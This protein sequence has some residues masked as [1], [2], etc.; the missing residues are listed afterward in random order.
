MISDKKLFTQLFLIIF[1]IGIIVLLFLPLISLTATAKILLAAAASALTSFMGMKIINRNIGRKTAELE[2]GIEKILETDNFDSELEIRER[3]SFGSLSAKINKI[4]RVKRVSEKALRESENLYKTIFETSE[5]AFAML[6]NNFQAFYI[7]KKFSELFGYKLDELEGKNLNKLLTPAENFKLNPESGIP[8]DF[9]LK[10]K[11]GTLIDVDLLSSPITIK[12]KPF[13]LLRFTDISEIKK[14]E[15]ETKKHQQQ[16]QQA[17]KLASLGLLVAGVAH[18]INNPN[19]FIA[20]NIPYIQQH[21]NEI[22]PVLDKYAA[23]NPEFKIGKLPYPLFKEDLADLLKDLN[24][25][26]KRITNIVNELKNFARSA[27]EKSDEIF[28]IKEV[29]NTALRL[30]ASQIKKKNITVNLDI[31]EEYPIKGNKQKLEQV[32][33]NCLTNALAAIEDNS[34]KIDICLSKN[35]DGIRAIIKDN[36]IGIPEDLLHLVFDPFFTTKSN[37]GGT[38][39]GLSVAKNIMDFMGFL[40]ELE[41]KVNTGTNII[42]TFPKEYCQ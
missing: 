41:S 40:I 25:G 19:S 23:E 22:F 29:I 21:F 42:L 37:S 17:D 33:V 11:D 13:V 16:L 12:E 4:I 7:N 34:G 5:D 24:E 39:L 18:E 3:D 27:P 1:F 9:K 38:G 26:S 2:Y 30:L 31:K 32:I 28:E 20:F 14:Y 36:G 6:D 10:R 8:F 15:E 35:S